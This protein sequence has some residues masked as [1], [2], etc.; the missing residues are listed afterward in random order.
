MG[1]SQKDLRAALI[2]VLQNRNAGFDVVIAASEAIATDARFNKWVATVAK[3]GSSN[4][5]MLDLVERYGGLV[6]EC[7]SAWGRFLADEN[8][9]QLLASLRAINSKLVELTEK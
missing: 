9:E 1:E 3:G 6:D 4:V 7:T 2:R 5:D 8:A